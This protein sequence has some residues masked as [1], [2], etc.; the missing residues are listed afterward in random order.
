[1]FKRITVVLATMLLASSSFAQSTEDL[2]QR[3]KAL[4]EK[5]VAIDEL[6]KMGHTFADAPSRQG[7]T[8]TIVIENG[9]IIGVADK[10]RGG[11]AAG[12]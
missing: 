8:H 10:R 9:Q 2:E 4:Q 7:D 11:S 3:L 12:Y 5:V 6:K 1:M